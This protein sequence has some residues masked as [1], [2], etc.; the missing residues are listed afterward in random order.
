MVNIERYGVSSGEQ[1]PVTAPR[2]FI[3]ASTIDHASDGR[4][5]TRRRRRHV[6]KRAASRLASLASLACASPHYCHFTTLPRY[7][8]DDCLTRCLPHRRQQLPN[9]AIPRDRG[10]Q[11]PPKAPEE[12]G[13]DHQTATRRR[14]PPAHTH[15]NA[16]T[17]SLR[18]S[19]RSCCMPSRAGG[20]ICPSS[21]LGRTNRR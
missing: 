6:T 11:D 20:S 5:S 1:V 7:N 9:G 18:P 19:P 8:H 2:H 16:S 17:A 14:R 4:R 10:H 12:R 21:A 15:S 13:S 3:V